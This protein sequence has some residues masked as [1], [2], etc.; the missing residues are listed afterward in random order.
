VDGYAGFNPVYETGHI[1][2]AAC[3]AHVRRKFYDLHIAHKSQ[4]A[5]EAMERIA[6]LYAI[7]KRFAATRRTNGARS[8]THAPGPYWTR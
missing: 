7:K 1:Q 6:E 4:V 5:A 2:E 8:E 3:W